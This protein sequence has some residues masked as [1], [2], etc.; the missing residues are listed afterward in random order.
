MVNLLI[1]KGAKIDAVTRDGLTS[2]HCAARSGH[3]E[4]VEILLKNHAP[5]LA[6]TKVSIV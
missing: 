6:K 1:P 3:G 5:I 4:V 2:L